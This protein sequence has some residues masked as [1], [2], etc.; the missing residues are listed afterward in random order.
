MVTGLG[1]TFK[2]CWVETIYLLGYTTALGFT[3]LSC[4]LVT[5]YVIIALI[6][7]NQYSVK[8][9]IQ[10]FFFFKHRTVLVLEL[11]ICLA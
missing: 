7:M 1:F 2:C 6:S 10:Q 9:I 11:E 8:S 5:T 4:R 3:A